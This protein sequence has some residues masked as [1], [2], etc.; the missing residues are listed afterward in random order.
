MMN[1]ADN[2]SSGAIQSTAS[3]QI[4]PP[5]GEA[6][7]TTFE[8]EQT[9]YG[10]MEFMGR[11]SPVHEGRTVVSA[12]FTLV[13]LLVV[14]GIISLLVSVLLPA[15]NKARQQANLI[16]CESR[17]RQMGQ[18]LS[19]YVTENNGLLP[20]GDVRH[21]PTGST[22]W[23]NP[24]SDPENQ[25][26][27]WYWTFTL[28]KEVQARITG[29]DGLVNNLSPMFRDVDT[30]D[31]GYGRYVNHYT[32][33]PRIF[34]DNWEPQTLQDGTSVSGQYVTGRKLSNIKPN[35]VFLFWDA[36]Q[37]AA[38]APGAPNNAYEQ[39]TE[40]DGNQLEYPNYLF[41][42]TPGYTLPYD[43]PV[44]PGTIHPVMNIA[45]DALLQKK[46]NRDFPNPSDGY[47]LS[48]LRFRHM[49]NTVLNALCLDGHVENRTVGTF[50]VLDICI[51]APG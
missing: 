48:H 6:K 50:M 20:Y 43:R 14:I 49:N 31:A 4:S 39:A 30:I 8:R 9:K 46:E 3:K 13:E 24:V 27:S 18:A 25:E 28:S 41:T 2:E 12:G 32:C 7:V 26:F 19:I 22:S 5:E 29:P 40:I 11:R 51:K 42:D 47:F 21:D 38:W 35:T 37:C 44:S 33:N 34:P 10:P 15:L 45:Q 23:E 16:D 36:P 17:L 1:V